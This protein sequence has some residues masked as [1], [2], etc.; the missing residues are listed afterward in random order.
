MHPNTLNFAT[1]NGLL[2]E[3]AAQSVSEAQAVINDATLPR[4]KAVKQLQNIGE[5][6]NTQAQALRY[7]AKRCGGPDCT[8]AALKTLF[9]T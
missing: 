1:V 4:S 5:K 3:F 8:P 7:I 2:A 9:K 6:Y